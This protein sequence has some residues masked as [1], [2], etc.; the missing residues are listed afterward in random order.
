MRAARTA[1]NRPALILPDQ[2]LT[3]AELRQ[4]AAGIASRWQAGGVPAGARLA[5]WV[6]DPQSLVLLLQACI[7]AGY[8]ACPISTRLPAT[9]ALRLV[10]RI[11][12]AA[13]ITDRS[14]ETDTSPSLT[15]FSAN[16]LL[17]GPVTGTIE[18]PESISESQPVS[19]IFTSGSTGEPKA[20][21]HSYGNHYY[22]ALGAGENI[23]FG[24]GDRWLLSLP[25]YHVGGLAI[26][27]RAM[28]G[29]GAVVVPQDRHNLAA[30]IR[31][32]RITHVSMVS[33]QL[34]RMLQD[35]QSVETLRGLKA[36][37]LGG[38]GMPRSLIE[39]A[40]E[41]GL[42][43]HTSYGLTEMA[44]QVTATPP[45]AALATLFTAG[46]LLP[47]RELKIHAH[48]EIL[49]KGRTRFL[50]YVH[51]DRL[52]EP[53][54]AE[55]W[56]ATGDLGH[57]NAQ[58]LLEV[59]GRKDNLFISGGENIQP[60]EI[61]QALLPFPGVL[62][63]IVVPVPDAEFGQRPVAFVEMEDDEGLDEASMRVFLAGRLARF[64]IPIA[65][66]PLPREL[67]QTG[68]KPGRRQLAALAEERM[69]KRR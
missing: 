69:S 14:V 15:I 47:Y 29:D 23:P 49:V 26:L 24:A 4:L 20:A 54:D 39:A 61:E 32:H 63:A 51:D 52:H 25:L 40:H 28:L 8:V 60:E 59:T 56:F 44:S 50:G 33:T 64:K 6:H 66:F 38:S 30:A 2:T 43:I 62:Q 67:A 7:A 17:K 58:G 16:T 41:Q 45:G 21:L 1:P 19:I 27:F 12:A 48:G 22:S 11:S 9:E 55:G 34:Y 3:Y 68:I 57:W 10:Q 37:L 31:A 18:F 53:F 46:R 36:I 35:P 65:F 13:L 42:A 5:M